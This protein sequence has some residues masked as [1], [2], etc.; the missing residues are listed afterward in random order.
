MEKKLGPRVEI[1]KK[2]IKQGQRKS[3]RVEKKKKFT[4][5][6]RRALGGPSSTKEVYLKGGGGKKPTPQSHQK[7]N[8]PG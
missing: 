5:K 2:K 7:K 1:K 3:T 4:I 8:H 6:Q